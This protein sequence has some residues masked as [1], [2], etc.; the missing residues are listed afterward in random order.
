[1]LKDSCDTEVSNLDLVIL[2]HEDVLS[3]QIT[4]QNLSIMNVLDSK[5]HLHEPVKD[6]IL[7]V[8]DCKY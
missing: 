3:L 1:M 8:Y 2:G 4:M 7:T 5:S 6:L